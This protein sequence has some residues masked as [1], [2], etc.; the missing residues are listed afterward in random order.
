LN[1]T[2]QNPALPGQRLL[3]D[4]AGK[5]AAHLTIRHADALNSR[6]RETSMQFDWRAFS[7]PVLE[8]FI[9]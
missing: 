1:Q 2:S 3:D 7:G 6:D 8:H 9:F 5:S 4:A